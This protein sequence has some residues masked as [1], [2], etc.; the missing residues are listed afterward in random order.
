[1]GVEELAL[2]VPVFGLAESELGCQVKGAVRR[3][4]PPVPPCP[5]SSIVLLL[6]AGGGYICLPW[7][8]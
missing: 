8:E 7:G 5:P 2:G 1:M 3:H 4:Q 6:P